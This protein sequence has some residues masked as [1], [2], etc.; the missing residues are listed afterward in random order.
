MV[1]DRADL[2][3]FL[4]HDNVS[5]V[6]AFPHGLAGLFKDLL[7]FYVVQQLAIALLMSFLNGGHGA[8]PG[9]QL[10]KACLLY[11]SPSPRDS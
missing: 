11:T 1:A 3:G 4:A 5:A 7:H 9:G 6:A 8:E 10:C 2:G